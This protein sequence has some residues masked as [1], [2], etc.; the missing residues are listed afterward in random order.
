MTEPLNKLDKIYIKFKDLKEKAIVDC[1]FDK[2]QMDSQFNNTLTIAWWIN[3]KSEWN[4]VFR[5]YDN[6]RKEKYRKLYE[7]YK[8]ES[9]LK[10]N[11]KEEL[12]L[13]I[14]SDNQYT[15][16]F[17]ICQVLKEIQEYIVSIVENLKGKN[18][19]QQRWLAYQNFINGR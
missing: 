1:N 18:F 17:M 13:F 4:Q 11:T 12:S 15:E 2:S 16:I 14:E 19:E 8:L 9:N 6:K 10:I 3:Q 5:I 7:F